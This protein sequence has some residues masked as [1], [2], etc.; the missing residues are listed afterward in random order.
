MDT[1]EGF[2]LT[3]NEKALFL[4]KAETKVKIIDSLILSEMVIYI[5]IL[6]Y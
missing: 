3:E 6:P 1:A 4:N 5:K 2:Y